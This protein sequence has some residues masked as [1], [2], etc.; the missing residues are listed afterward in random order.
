[1]KE[2]GKDSITKAKSETSTP[3]C[4]QDQQSAV[5]LDEKNDLEEKGKDR[6]KQKRTGINGDGKSG[7]DPQKRALRRNKIVD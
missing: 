4:A 6:K 2:N 1:M 3:R 5:V 7:T